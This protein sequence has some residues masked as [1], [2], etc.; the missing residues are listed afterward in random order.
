M[1]EEEKNHDIIHSGRVKFKA[2]LASRWSTVYAT[3]CR[4]CL[5]VYRNP[6]CQ[7]PIYS[8]ESSDSWISAK[9]SDKSSLFILN[10][11]EKNTTSSKVFLF[12]TESE[13]L[14][15][16]WLNAFKSGGWTSAIQ[17][18]KILYHRRSADNFV[19]RNNGPSQDSGPGGSLRGTRS[20]S[21]PTFFVS[22]VTRGCDDSGLYLRNK[23][24]GRKNISSLFPNSKIDLSGNIGA[25]AVGSRHDTSSDNSSSTPTNMEE[26]FAQIDRGEK[27]STNKTI[28]GDDPHEKKETDLSDKQTV[29]NSREGDFKTADRAKLVIVSEIGINPVVSKNNIDKMSKNKEQVADSNDFDNT[30]AGSILIGDLSDIKCKKPSILN[31]NTRTPRI[32]RFDHSKTFFDPSP[33]MKGKLIETEHR[34][35]KTSCTHRG[36]HIRLLESDETERQSDEDVE[37]RSKEDPTSERSIAAEVTN[38]DTD[39]RDISNDRIRK[40]SIA[41]SEDDVDGDGGV[42]HSGTP[43]AYFS[44]LE[45]GYCS[46]E[47]LSTNGSVDNRKSTATIDEDLNSNEGQLEASSEI[48]SDLESRWQKDKE[49]LIDTNEPSNPMPS[50]CNI[51]AKSD[52]GPGTAETGPTSTSPTSMATRVANR[53]STLKLEKRSSMSQLLSQIK[54]RLPGR[55]GK[56]YKQQSR[57]DNAKSDGSE[58]LLWQNNGKW[59]E[60]WSMVSQNCLVL[61]KDSTRDLPDFALDIR[62]CRLDVPEENNEQG[63]LS[64]MLIEKDGKKQHFAAVSED[65]YKTLMALFSTI[66][67]S[68]Q[69]TGVTNGNMSD[70]DEDARLDH[71]IVPYP[72]CESFHKDVTGSA[73]QTDIQESIDSGTDGDISC[74]EGSDASNAGVDQY[75]KRWKD[76]VARRKKTNSAPQQIVSS[77][78]DEV[79]NAV[80]QEDKEPTDNIRQPYRTVGASIS[81]PPSS[82]SASVS[83]LNRGRSRDLQNHNK[84]TDFLNVNGMERR[85]IKSRY[86]VPD[87]GQLKLANKVECDRERMSC[88]KEVQKL[89]EAHGNKRYPKSPVASKTRFS[90]MYVSAPSSPIF[91]ENGNDQRVGSL[92]QLLQASPKRSSFVNADQS[93]STPQ[94]STPKGKSRNGH[95]DSRI[96]LSQS[97]N[98]SHSY[99]DT[100]DIYDNYNEQQTLLMKRRN[101]L[102]LKKKYFNEKIKALREKTKQPTAKTEGAEVAEEEKNLSMLENS[103]NDIE[104]EIESINLKVDVPATEDFKDEKRKSKQNFLKLRSTQKATTPIGSR[105]SDTL[106]NG[107]DNSTTNSR[108]SPPMRK[109]SFSHNFRLFGHSGKRDSSINGLNSSTAVASSV[110]NFHEQQLLQSEPMINNVGNYR[111]LG[112]AEDGKFERQRS[113]KTSSVSSLQGSDEVDGRLDVERGIHKDALSKIEDFE[114]FAVELTAKRV[115]DYVDV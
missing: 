100:F 42:F 31:G 69:H 82:R 1:S 38:L 63:F 60:R 73:S 97:L 95:S 94:N 32:T 10:A 4:R 68:S 106:K 9:R 36:E 12:D 34:T 108:V 62:S 55:K 113:R 67:Q 15:S 16:A 87:F 114:Q 11:T 56:G 105:R 76:K 96:D 47:S 61:F 41:H 72:D 13:S 102:Q 66:L 89:K 33:D 30:S 39:E 52:E 98:L 109:R 51:S 43:G 24:K 64:F 90:S 80:V 50:E 111:D 28:H 54:D 23:S 37:H 83:V 65:S 70:A 107:T 27:V 3:L 58:M 85:V 22:G 7:E 84:S 26:S 17:G 74:F 103:L 49:S 71:A 93:P 40:A 20:I 57:K 29:N 53:P 46:K 86:S 6:E 78:N 19:V 2:G 5:C 35:R 112:S 48:T 77:S 14:L 8:F 75:A 79:D 115:T 99:S 101:S 81:S 18:E 88:L 44:Y 45:S 21:A 59:K 110:E 25:N 91:D 104:Q 92:Q